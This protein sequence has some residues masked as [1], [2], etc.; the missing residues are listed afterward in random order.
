VRVLRELTARVSGPH[1]L[2][3]SMFFGSFAW[4][5]VFVSLPF[6]I[7]RVSPLDA[8]STLRWTGWIVGITSLVT[9]LTS[10]IWGR[11]AAR[12]N[13][14]ACYVAVEALQGLGFFVMALARTL[15]ELFLARLI[16]GAMGAAS[17]LG[18]IMV[19]RGAEG[20]EIRRR[21]AALQ[22]SM[23]VG[24][25]IGPLFGAI[26]AARLGIRG[27][28]VLGGTILI[29][30]AALVHWAVPRPP[31]ARQAGAA[32]RPVRPRE[33]AV[34][35]LIVLG[36]SIQVFYFTSILPH[37]LPGLGVEAERTLEVGGVLIF[38]SGVAA[39]LG[40]VAVPRLGELF[41]ERRLIG[42]LLVASSV[43]VA[44]LAVVGS[45][46]AYGGLRFLQVL[47]IAPVFPLI[48][49]RVVQHAGGSAIGVINAARIGAGFIGPVA[50]TS[51]L[52][53]TSPAFVYCLLASIGL[54]CVPLVRLRERGART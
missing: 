17:T 12:G 16:L 7:Q 13:P 19:G 24:Q 2:A 8:T 45:V 39:A 28:F 3:V 35:T 51:L 33:V 48:V 50:A 43:S 54:A 32:A 15:P 1:L 22:S 42:G 26:A 21:V 25:V 6:H 47:S 38:I 53:W 5:F 30:C 11:Y 37:V 49:S 14:K 9:V 29:G 46:W 40:A 18:F 31:D 20:A 36:G 41:P 23:T 4:S 44:A 27:S 34:V 10:P 52:A